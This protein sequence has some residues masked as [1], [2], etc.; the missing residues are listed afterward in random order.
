[1]IQ[2]ARTFRHVLGVSLLAA[3][4]VASQA[5]V[6]GFV[7]NETGNSTDLMNFIMTQ[8]GNPINTNV[9]FDAMSTGALDNNFYTA[10]EG[11]TFSTS[12][13]VNTIFN[14]AGPGQGNTFSSPLSTGEGAHAASNYLKDGTGVSALTISFD[15]PVWAAGIFLIDYFNPFGNNPMTIEAYSGI[16]GTGSLLGSFD[17]VAFNFQKNNLYFMGIGST[18]GDILSIRLVDTTSNTGD[19]LGYDN[20]IFAKANAVDTPMSAMLVTMG[21]IGLCARRR[22]K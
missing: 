10:T 21:L 17:S 19:K 3:T 16:D 11:V 8:T 15:M 4:S 2:V 14:G 12:G 22:Q 6:V 20:L 18:G 7:N 5:A 13:D 9:D 1:M